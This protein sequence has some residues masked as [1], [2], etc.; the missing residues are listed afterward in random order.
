MA[1]GL[2]AL[3]LLGLLG[4]AWE[5]WASARERR[6]VARQ[7]SFVQLDETLIHVALQG[8]RRSIDQPVVVMDGGLTNG[9]LAWPAVVQALGPDWLVLTFD[10]A[11][12]LWSTPARGPRD[13]EA[14]LAD[15]RAVLAALHLA[16]PWLLVTHSYSGHIARLH[17]ARHP[18]EVA[19][20]VLVETIPAPLARS[21][22]HSG[23]AR[24]LRWKLP[25]A[26]FGIWRLWRLRQGLPPLPEAVA[27]DT[28][29][30]AWTRLSQSHQ[31]LQATR[32]ELA[33]FVADTGAVDAAPPPPQPCIVLAS[34]RGAV[35]V[36]AGLTEAEAHDQALAAQR[37]L[38]ARL[39]R[40]ELRV[41]AESDH[42]IPWNLPG[43]VAQAIQ[44]VAARARPAPG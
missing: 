31:D 14:N 36:T 17:A 13:A 44:D 9:S 11:G 34:T 35:A 28:M 30:A 8:R 37:D 23:F 6:R 43:M 21:V 1:W 3:I 38:A 40:G 22:V 20:L 33:S 26:R 7:G 16:P 32:A 29:V 15:Q 18:E 41:T 27:P 12:H 25:A 39:P 24:S 10:R 2:A 42:E 5:G 19:G 4:A